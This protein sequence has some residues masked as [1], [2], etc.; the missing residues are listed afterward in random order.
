MREAMSV[1]GLTSIE[2]SVIKEAKDRL[3]CAISMGY[4]HVWKIA[5]PVMWHFAIG[6]IKRA[7]LT[8]S[9]MISWHTGIFQIH[10]EHVPNQQLAS[11]PMPNMSIS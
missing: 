1:R 9:M 8:V 4:T 7:E 6:C 5:V 10:P 11:L 3:R 2:A